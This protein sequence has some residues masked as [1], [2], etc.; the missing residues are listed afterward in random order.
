MC[1]SRGKKNVL[2]A[3]GCQKN[4]HGNKRIKK[5]EGTKNEKEEPEAKRKRRSKN[6]PPEE[7]R[8]ELTGKVIK[9]VSLFYSLAIQNNPND[10]QAMKNAIWAGFYHRISTNEK[11]Q[12]QYCTRY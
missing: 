9:G 3:Q 8:T 12:H 7:K 11:P 1:P 5:K 10:K 4:S 2:K 6:T